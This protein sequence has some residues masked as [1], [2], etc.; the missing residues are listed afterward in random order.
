MGILIDI[1][2]HRQQM[3]VKAVNMVILKDS[4]E[5][6]HRSERWN[7]ML[8]MNLIVDKIVQFIKFFHR[9]FK[10]TQVYSNSLL[11]VLNFSQVSE[12]QAS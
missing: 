9:V 2:A 3:K 10:V 8:G 5:K 1:L 6:A 12:W 7:F 11:C 4:H